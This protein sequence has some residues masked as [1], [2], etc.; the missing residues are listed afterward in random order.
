M[1]A[2]Q[3]RGQSGAGMAVF[4]GNGEMHIQKGSGLVTEAL[5]DVDLNYLKF[6]SEG[7]TVIGHD[8]YSTSGKTSTE[9]SVNLA[10]PF[11]GERSHFALAHNGH[12]EG[13]GLFATSL[14]YDVSG[15]ESDSEAL[16]SL[17]D[18][19]T[20]ERGDLLEAIHIALPNLEGAINLV[21]NESDR[22]IGV[23]DSRG[24]RP[25]CVGRLP[26]GGIILASETIALDT[27]GAKLIKEVEPGEIIIVDKDGMR[28]EWL[29]TERKE[30][31]CLFE[32]IYF[33]HPNSKLQGRNVNQVREKLGRL[34]GEDHPVDADMVVGVQK[35]GAIYSRG[36]SHQTGLIEELA[37]TKNEYVNRTFIEDNQLSRE[38]A[39]GLKHQPNRSI[40]EDKR[41]VLVDDSIVRGTT[42]KRLITML[43]GSGVTEVHVRIPSPPYISPC[44]Y[45]MDTPNPYHLLAYERSIK[46]MC[47]YIGADSLE[48]LSIE[49]V[50][51]GI[52]GTEVSQ[53]FENGEYIGKLCMSCMTGKYPSP[54]PVTI[55]QN[56]VG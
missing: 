29:N 49:R 42:M 8:R 28:S 51:E 5:Q 15:A 19:I 18:Q 4:D 40:L 38:D 23:R 9:D 17:L 14:G 1:Q 26:N 25:L 10:H 37:I 52:E 43:R 39:V 41:I 46:D 48:F 27:I 36:Y 35:T 55:N 11:G 24:Y 50:I 16:T 44:Y 7:R 22:L 45:G 12:I 56:K 20:E 2:L 33:A 3:H 53:S 54:V 30:T 13:I 34:L 47:S 21:M 32:D 31:F 6:H